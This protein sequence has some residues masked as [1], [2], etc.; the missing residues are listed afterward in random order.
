MGC[1]LIG[2]AREPMMALGC[3]QAQHCHTGQCPAGIA[4]Q[5]RWLQ[6]GVNVTDKTQRVANYIQ[7]FRKE[8]LTLSHAAGYKHPCLFDGA[9]IEFSSGVNKFTTLEDILGYRCD[10][11]G[12]P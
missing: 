8:I 3:I 11:S 7:G 1:D 12:A 4:T 5:N 2:V 10:P 6:S 9:D